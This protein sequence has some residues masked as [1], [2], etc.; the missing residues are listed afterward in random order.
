M[1]HG[2]PDIIIAQTPELAVDMS[3]ELPTQNLE[4]SDKL[5][6]GFSL[7][8]PPMTLNSRS[9]ATGP[10]SYDSGVRLCLSLAFCSVRLTYDV[11]TRMTGDALVGMC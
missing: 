2:F 7:H 6:N 9:A 10:T 1:S 3:S 11:M 4:A 5:V 8:Q